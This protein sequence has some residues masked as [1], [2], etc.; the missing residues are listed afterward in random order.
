[1][2]IFTYLVT[3]G[4]FAV[5]AKAEANLPPMPRELT[6][7]AADTADTAPR[8]LLLEIIVVCSFC[9]D[10]VSECNTMALICTNRL[11]PLGYFH[12]GWFL[13]IVPSVDFDYGTTNIWRS[14]GGGTGAG[15]VDYRVLRR[16][17]PGQSGSGRFWRIH[18]GRQGRG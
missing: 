7:P 12:R 9:F 1:M 15:H 18:P 13:G 4:A 8:K 5:E 17:F 10:N 16:R 2:A 11:F 3:S 6:S 14:Q